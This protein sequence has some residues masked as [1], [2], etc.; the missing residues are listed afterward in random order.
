MKAL[1]VIQFA[2][3]ATIF[4]L[5]G[6]I[7]A[8]LNKQRKMNFSNWIQNSNVV[9]KDFSLLTSTTLA[10]LIYAFASWTFFF[11]YIA[12]FSIITVSTIVYSYFK[13]RK[14]RK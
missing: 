14:S 4:Y 8:I 7:L 1:N 10:V 11:I 9:G 13:L 12:I 5:S 3:F 6:I 2:L